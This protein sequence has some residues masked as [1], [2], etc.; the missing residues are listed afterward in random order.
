MLSIGKMGKSSLT[1]YSH[2]EREDYYQDGTESPGI[3][4]GR[5]TEPLGLFGKDIDHLTFH[6]IFSGFGPNGEKLVQNAGEPSRHKGND[7]TF[8]P[9]KEVD[10]FWALSDGRERA[11]IEQIVIES[12]KDALDYL[13]E[14]ALFTR[15]GK[16]GEIIEKGAGMVS[17]LFLHRTSRAQDPLLHVHCPTANLCLRAD[18]SWG[19]MLG[20]TATEKAK[21]FRKTR[22]PFYREKMAA[23][24]LFR[25]SLAARLEK[26][27]GLPI[28]REGTTFTIEGIPKTLVELFSTRRRQIVEELSARGE[29]GAKSAQRVT[30]FTRQAKTHVPKEEL[31]RRWREQAADFDL[32][33]IP[34]RFPTRDLAKEGEAALT[35]ARAVVEKGKRPPTRTDVVRRLAEESQGIGLDAAAVLAIVEKVFTYPVKEPRRKDVARTVREAARAVK[36]LARSRAH[37]VAPATLFLARKQ[38]EFLRGERFS[39]LERE[40]LRKATRERGAVHVI[41]NEAESVL[42][43]VLR[44]AAIAWGKSDLR[45]L[46]ISP[47]PRRKDFLQE[48]SGIRAALSV[49][50]L[51]RGLSTRRGL[52]RGYESALKKSWEEYGFRGFPTK[53]GFVKYALKASGK[54]VR[55]DEK[56]VVVLDNPEALSLRALTSVIKHVEKAGGK[57]VC[58]SQNPLLHKEET[59]LEAMDRIIGAKQIK[60]EV[61]ELMKQERSM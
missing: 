40:A 55:L 31:F 45:P 10:V 47:S 32:S 14:H 39:T 21:D 49:R 22:L 60:A 43:T 56:T 16:G 17:A 42:P 50:E 44:T 23:G 41:T 27:L 52:L 24:A 25:A 29:S 11:V 36:R 4:Y 51:L 37:A 48:A 33:V 7:A 18:G 38:A 1:Y 61:E 3:W 26:E 15:R 2:L 28:R 9:P 30:L 34:R 13:E 20:I 57:L 46:L 53:G 12:A 5:G 19:T 6:Q 8:S 35:R 54:W 59:S 58:L